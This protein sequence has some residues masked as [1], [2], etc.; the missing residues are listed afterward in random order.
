MFRI[1][2]SKVSSY[3]KEN[4]SSGWGVTRIEAL[5]LVR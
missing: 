5:R 3:H 2:F 1:E 4:I